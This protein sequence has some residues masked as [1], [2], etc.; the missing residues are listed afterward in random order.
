[1]GQRASLRP[2]W[3]QLS[4]LQLCLSE[5]TVRAALTVSVYLFH[6]SNEHSIINGHTGRARTQGMPKH[7]TCPKGD[8]IGGQFLAFTQHLSATCV[9]F[10]P[11]C[12]IS[13]HPVGSSLGG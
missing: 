10:I 12:T 6:T 3:A 9:L 11:S 1:M 7:K 2:V 5:V 8:V 4:P 13:G